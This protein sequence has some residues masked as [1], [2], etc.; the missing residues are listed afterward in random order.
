MCSEEAVAVVTFSCSMPGYTP[1][2]PLGYFYLLIAFLFCARG[3][4]PCV[5]CPCLW[6]CFVPY[7]MQD[8][9]VFGL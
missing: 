2:D 1:N 4:A 5:V 7:P 6:L 9:P 3:T 8:L